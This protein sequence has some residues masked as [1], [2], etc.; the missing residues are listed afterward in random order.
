VEKDEEIYK[1]E[2]R[3]LSRIA[4]YG[5]V[6]S[7]VPT[8]LMLVFLILL[9]G[10]F[11]AVGKLFIGVTAV[12]FGLISLSL[13]LNTKYR[14]ACPKCKKPFFGKFELFAAYF[15][16]CKNCGFCIVPGKPIKLDGQDL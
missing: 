11:V 1:R 2:H 10:A 14:L 16:C 12:L 4:T 5:A 6:C 13:Y 3:Q 8:M 9:C 7:K 15:D